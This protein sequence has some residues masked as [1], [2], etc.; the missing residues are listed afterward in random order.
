MTPAARFLLDGLREAVTD[1]EARAILAP[2]LAEIVP[3]FGADPTPADDGW[4][5]TK[6]AAAYL[7][8]TPNALHKA[9]AARTLRFEQDAPGGKCWFRR[10]DLDAWRR[11]ER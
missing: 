8:V 3:G 9:T 10:E 1:P 4:L 11:G 7:G 2:L 5:D 6:R